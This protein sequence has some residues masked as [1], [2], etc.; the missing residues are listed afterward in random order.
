ALRD[1]VF[2]EPG[3]ETAALLDQTVF[4]QAG[5]FAVEVAL[6]ELLASWGVRADYLAGHSIGEVTAAYVSGMLSLADA[7]TLVAARGRLMQ[8]LPSGG[9]MRGGGRG[10]GERSGV[11]GGVGCRRRGGVGGDDRS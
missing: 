2:A 6:W 9:V 11:G 7:C 4:A 1:V 5:L 10:G 3:S 8:A